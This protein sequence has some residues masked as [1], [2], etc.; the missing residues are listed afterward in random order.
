MSPPPSVPEIRLVG[1][2]DSLPGAGKVSPSPAGDE[3]VPS[4]AAVQSAVQE[5]IALF[6]AACQAGAPSGRRE[7]EHLEDAPRNRRGRAVQENLCL[8]CGFGCASPA[9][10]LCG[11]GGRQGASCG[12]AWPGCVCAVLGR[13]LHGAPGRSLC[14]ASVSMSTL[15]IG[16][17]RAW[18]FELI[19]TLALSSCTPSEWAQVTWRVPAPQGWISVPHGESSRCAG[20]L[21]TECTASH[22]KCMFALVHMGAGE[23]AV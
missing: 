9:C 22:S 7:V 16:T 23:R 2:S 18:E 5:L 21:S 17:G 20:V 4:D 8:R 6:E 12:C 3:G 14:A 15:C 10:V 1:E 13:V 19:G 11:S